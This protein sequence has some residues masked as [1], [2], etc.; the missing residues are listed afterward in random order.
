[1]RP[2]VRRRKPEPLRRGAKPPQPTI[3]GQFQHP[4]TGDHHKTQWPTN[5][6]ENAAIDQAELGPGSDVPQ[7]APENN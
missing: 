4:G 7:E 3:V 1:M 6:E 5:E 2:L